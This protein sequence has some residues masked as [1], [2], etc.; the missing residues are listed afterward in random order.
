LVE[1]FQE[2]LFIKAWQVSI[3]GEGEQLIAEIHED[4]VVAG[5]MIGEGGFELGGHEAGI[6]GGFEQVVEAGEEFVA[7]CILEDEAA[8]DA[9][10]EW[11]QLGAAKTLDQTC[12]TGE[13]DTEE[14]ARIEIL[15]GQH[16]QLTQD[17]GKRLLGLVDDE[18]RAAEG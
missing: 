4:A 11:H 10:T 17:G 2:K 15:A 1:G 8:A 16:T 7:G 6:A 13:D 9:A 14:L 12:I 18:D 3:S 5:S